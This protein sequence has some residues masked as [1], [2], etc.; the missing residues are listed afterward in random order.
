[1]ITFSG[2]TFCAV[3]SLALMGRL[4]AIPKGRRRELLV[5]WCLDRQGA[6]F[7]GRPHKPNDTCYSWWIGASLTILGGELVFFLF[8]LNSLAYHWTKPEGNLAFNL[9]CS[10][11]FGGF[12][13]EPES[14]PDIMHSYFGL[15]GV[16]LM[17]EESLQRIYPL[18][19]LTTRAAA[20]SYS[21]PKTLEEWLSE[22]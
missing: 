6:G 22:R 16:S 14:F 10:S 1:M 20:K 7:H 21:P 19:G 5:K 8:E 17:G 3:A 15:A 11:K 12:S 4:D 2:S 9:S 13:K 18:W